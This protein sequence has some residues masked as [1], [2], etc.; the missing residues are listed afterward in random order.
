M[1]INS[2][3]C[4]IWN[5]G[6]PTLFLDDNDYFQPMV[7]VWGR[8]YQFDWKYRIKQYLCKIFVRTYTLKW[9]K[10]FSYIKKKKQ[11]NYWFW[12]KWHLHHRCKHTVKTEITILLP[13]KDIWVKIFDKKKMVHVPQNNWCVHVILGSSYSIYEFTSWVAAIEGTFTRQWCT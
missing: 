9:D 11:K 1:I 5:I 12:V 4:K 3:F 6:Q 10:V 2:K 13:L 8:G 7:W